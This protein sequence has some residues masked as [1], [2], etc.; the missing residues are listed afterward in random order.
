MDENSYLAIFL[1]LFKWLHKAYIDIYCMRE[2]L[3]NSRRVAGLGEIFI[4]Q[5]FLSV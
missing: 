3:R 4:Q 2:N 5:N 1:V